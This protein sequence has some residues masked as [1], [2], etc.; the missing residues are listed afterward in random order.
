MLSVFTKNWHIWYLK[1][2]T[3]KSGLIFLKL[4][5]RNPFLGKSGSE[6]S[7]FLPV[8]PE[9]WHEEYLEDDDSYSNTSLMNF[10]P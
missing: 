3:S 2:S 9:I 6:K 7:K 5:R 4:R 8:L 10:P 1:G